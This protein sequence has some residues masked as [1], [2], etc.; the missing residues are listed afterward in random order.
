[1]NCPNC[2]S[3]TLTDHEFC[4]SCGTGLL[5][6]KP[7]SF[8]PQCWG[9]M[10]LVTT[11]G[12]LMIAMTGK[13]LDVRWLTFTGVFITMGGMFFVAAYAMLRQSRPRKRKASRAPRPDSLSPAET[14][15][16]LPPLAATDFI[17]SVTEPTT[18]LLRQPVPNKTDSR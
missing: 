9:L 14:T 8:R 18:D 17:T 5:E 13:M 1:M 6:D 12:G 2:G 16:K 7:R 10:T 15:N 4:R 3:P 11:F